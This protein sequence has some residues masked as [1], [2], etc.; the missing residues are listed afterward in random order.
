MEVKHIARTKPNFNLW[1]IF[2]LLNV[3]I[4]KDNIEILQSV[5]CLEELAEKLLIILDR[6]IIDDE[7]KESPRMMSL[8]DI[9]KEAIIWTKRKQ[10]LD[11]MKN[12]P[13][14]EKDYIYSSQSSVYR[15]PC[16]TCILPSYSSCLECK[17]KNK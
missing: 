2:K 7:I 3:K 8:S 9:E 12:I 15:Y 11:Y 17:N 1:R 10:V 4:D 13:I 6:I 16:E 14:K 5:T